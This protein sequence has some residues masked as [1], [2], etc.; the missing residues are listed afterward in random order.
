MIIA[1]DFD[2]TITK[3]NEYPNCGELRE[4]IKEC[5]D[6]LIYQD[7]CK[8]II[9]TCRS[10]N[11]PDQCNAYV[12]MINYLGKNDISFHVINN[13][14]N[15]SKDFNPYKPYWNILVDDSALGFNPNWTGDDIYKL[16]K[17]RIK[18]DS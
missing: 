18:R 14:V 12:D 10:I 9:F 2:G 4:G 3:R 15:P 5:I 7:K 1:F 17:E 13:N 8:I 6:K 11:T 16:I